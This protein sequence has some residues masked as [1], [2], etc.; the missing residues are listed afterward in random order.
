MTEK[1]ALQLAGLQ[2][3]VLW[4]EF[5]P[6]AMSRYSDVESYLPQRILT[7]NRR[8][9]EEEWKGAL[10][11]AHKVRPLVALRNANSVRKEAIFSG[12]TPSMAVP[13]FRK[14]HLLCHTNLSNDSSL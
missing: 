5:D 7:E 14:T 11:G 6:R 10:A 3:Q 8:M 12:G 9:S 1:V 13:L 2:A 4:G